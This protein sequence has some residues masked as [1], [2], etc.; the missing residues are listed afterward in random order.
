MNIAIVFRVDW[1]LQEF[2][3]EISRGF[4]V[5]V[6]SVD[7]KDQSA[8]CVS[9]AQGRKPRREKDVRDITSTSVMPCAGWPIRN[10]IRQ[11]VGAESG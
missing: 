11:V 1:M 3:R 9:V 2:S 8:I 10:R 4:P 6:L 7:S 5:G